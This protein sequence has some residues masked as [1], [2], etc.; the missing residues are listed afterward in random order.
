MSLFAI[1]TTLFAVTMVSS[2]VLHTFYKDRPVLNNISIYLMVLAFI[3]SLINASL[4]LY[5]EAGVLLE[6]VSMGVSVYVV[7]Y[8]YKLVFNDKH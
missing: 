8:I 5:V 4:L 1:V 3:L 2:I 7:Y 6:V